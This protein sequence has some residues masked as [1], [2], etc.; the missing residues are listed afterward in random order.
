MVEIEKDVPLLRTTLTIRAVENKIQQLFDSKVIGGTVHLSIGQEVIDASIIGAYDNPLVFGNHRSHGQYIA[1]TGDVRGLF[2]QVF[3]GMSQHLYYPDKFLSHG[4]Q[5][6]LVPVAFGAA[7]AFKQR[8]LDRRVICFIG[9][10]TLGQGVVYETLNLMGR[11]N[12][13]MTLIV[14]DNR[15]SMAETRQGLEGWGSPVFPEVFE[16]TQYFGDVRGF[17]EYTDSDIAVFAASRLCGHS[18]NDTQM[19]RPKEERTPGW[20]AQNDPLQ[21]FL[22]DPMLEGL[23]RQ[24]ETEVE[25]IAND[26]Q[27]RHQ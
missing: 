26:V 11:Y 12:P 14:I 3:S 22:E 27:K 9:D 13:R 23:R 1:A 2:E 25:E 15:Y 18:C 20:V 5:G 16:V 17:P 19:Y 7:M 24:I 4:I 6:S 10:G 8:G 21:V